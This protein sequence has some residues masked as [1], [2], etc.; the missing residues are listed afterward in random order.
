MTRHETARSEARR[1]RVLIVDDAVVVRGLFGRWMEADGRFEVL[2][3]CADGQSAIA[4]ARKHKP[5][6]IVLDLEMPVMDGMTALP[7]LIKA[8]PDSAIL[9]ASTLTKRNAKLSMR[10]LAL[11]AAEV[12]PKPDSNRD[13]TLSTSFREEFIAKIAGL[14]GAHVTALRPS[15]Q[16]PA[17][18]TP[19]AVSARE[20]RPSQSLAGHVAQLPRYLVIG[21]STG[22]PRAVAQVLSDMK[23]ILPHVTTLIVQHMPPMFTASFAE[24]MQAQINMPVREPGDGERLQPGAI[25][26]AQGGRHMGIAR[27]NGHPIVRI[28][29]GPPVKF[30]RPSV[31]VL[32][33]DAARELGNA[34]LAMVLTG[35]GSDGCDGAKLLRQAGVAVIAQ[36]EESSVV[37]GMPG[38][39]TKA[40][41]ASLVMPLTD[42]GPA[43]REL[44]ASGM[45]MAASRKTERAS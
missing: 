26:I 8:S 14:A 41:L 40:G 37:W 10:C 15:V 27:E 32:F 19:Q 11:G 2:P 17:K 12:L 6:V 45:L 23:T 21:A 44:I 22:G 13:L 43:I 4:A 24:Q 16:V 39:V 9:I 1:P 25:Y 28:S 30:C 29:D 3:T 7:E 36:D 18:P 38:A 34:A 31:D 33:A 42:I 35:M 5:H 20:L